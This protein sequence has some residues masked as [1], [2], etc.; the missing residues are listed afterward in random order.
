MIRFL[1]IAEHYRELDLER[2]AFDDRA[3]LSITIMLESFNK[4]E[5][6]SRAMLLL[7]CLTLFRA[8]FWRVPSASISGYILHGDPKDMSSC[9]WYKPLMKHFEVPEAGCCQRDIWKRLEFQIKT[10]LGDFIEDGL[11]PPDVRAELDALVSFAL[12]YS[13]AGGR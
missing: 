4:L 9:S 12:L 8:L 6:T 2:L 11:A 13:R 7:A 3:L 10:Y 5:P 1:V